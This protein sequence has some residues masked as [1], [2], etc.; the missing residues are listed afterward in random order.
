MH[1][2]I[3]ENPVFARLGFHPQDFVTG[4]ELDEVAT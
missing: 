1:T 4:G 3:N 2:N